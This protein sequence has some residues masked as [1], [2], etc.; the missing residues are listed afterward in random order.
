MLKQLVRRVLPHR[1]DYYRDRF[2]RRMPSARLLGV[3]RELG[4]REG[5]TVFVHAR[6]SALGYLPDGPAGVLQ[7]LRAAVGPTGTI[8]MPSFPFSASVEEYLATR[9]TFDVARTPSKS[10][11]I[12]EL[13]RQQPGAV[14]S[15]H[16]T[17]PIVAL[18]PLARELT[19]GH[20]Q[21]DTPCGPSSAFAR[22]AG[23]DALQL[24]LGVPIGTLMHHLHEMLDYPN[25]FLDERVP[26]P[27][28]DE[29]GRERV[30]PVRPYRRGIWQVFYLGEDEGGQRMGVMPR[31]FPLLYHGRD[32]V[33]RD[34]PARQRAYA[35][36]LRIRSE[37]E[38]AGDTHAV[39]VNGTWLESFRVRAYMDYGLREGRRLLDAHAH[40]YDP[41]T[42]EA[43]LAAGQYPQ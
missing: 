25:L 31:D 3:L 42:L 39:H 7:T 17:H 1:R 22:L 43:L 29:H 2:F 41:R 13:F 28:I 37:F 34:D 32:A 5:A 23:V 14:R 15:L 6:L 38:R 9:P 21:D 40:R 35:E 36:L 26:V 30:L 4:V 11:T 24:R 19:E 18:G 8:V 10:G 12:T 20:E 33:Y 27:T 16:P